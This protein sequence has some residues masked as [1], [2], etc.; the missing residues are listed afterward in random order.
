M[1]D[2]MGSK[3]D[4]KRAPGQRP[5]A[6]PV[7]CAKEQFAVG[8]CGICLP[9]AATVAVPADPLTDVGDR[10]A[11]EHHQV[12]AVHH[13][14]MPDPPFSASGWASSPPSLRAS[15]LSLPNCS[16]QAHSS[17]SSCSSTA[18]GMESGTF[19]ASICGKGA[20]CGRVR[21]DAPKRR[22]IENIGA[23]RWPL[24]RSP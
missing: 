14:G 17:M 2:V 16:M 19:T 23:E 11:G 10:L 9:T 13:E 1:E 6:E 12:E 18:G 21:G 7:A 8:L 24:S 3:L 4:G 15:W 20:A 22:D 5:V